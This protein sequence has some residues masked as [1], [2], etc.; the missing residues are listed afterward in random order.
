VDSLKRQLLIS[1]GGLYDPSFRLAI[2][3]I[4]EH[5]AERAVGLILNRPL[6][7]PVSGL[8]PPLATEREQLQCETVFPP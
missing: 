6:D 4:G 5:G 7:L 2:V 3:L 1:G 8:A